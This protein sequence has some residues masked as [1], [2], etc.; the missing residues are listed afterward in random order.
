MPPTEVRLYRDD[1]GTVPLLEWLEKIEKRNRKAYDKCR[2]YLQR[3][4]LFGRDLRRPT[5]D[6]L[7]DGVYE[8]RINYQRV[9]YRI[10]Y[11]FA[12]ADIVL[13]THGITKERAVPPQQIDLAIERLAKYRGNPSKY[14]FRGEITDDSE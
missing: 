12:G 7:R 6:M 1:D 10:L 13:V 3:L 14:C 9:N 4:A 8:L 2:S 5:A 11:G